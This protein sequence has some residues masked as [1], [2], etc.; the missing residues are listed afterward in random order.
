LQIQD[1]GRFTLH[2]RTP[3]GVFSCYPLVTRS[4]ARQGCRPYP[5]KLVEGIFSEV[6]IAAVYRVGALHRRKTAQPRS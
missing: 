1:A 4:K 2:F 5:P 6:C 3:S